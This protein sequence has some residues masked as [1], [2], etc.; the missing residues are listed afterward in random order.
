MARFEEPLGQQLFIN[1]GHGHPRNSQLLCQRAGRGQPNA[2]LEGVM[3]HAFAEETHQLFAQGQWAVSGGEKGVPDRVSRGAFFHK[4]DIRIRRNKW[5]KL[6]V[7]SGYF[8]QSIL[9]PYWLH[10]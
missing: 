9:Y 6:T 2:G 8:N 10:C 1:A 7:E 4:K 3:G 5:S